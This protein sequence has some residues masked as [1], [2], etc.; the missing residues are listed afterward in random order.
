MKK[1]IKATINFHSN[2]NQKLADSPG[3]SASKPRL[4]SKSNERGSLLQSFQKPMSS[5]QDTKVVRNH[6]EQK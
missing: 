1:N 4:N 6:I 2:F 5:L 3:R